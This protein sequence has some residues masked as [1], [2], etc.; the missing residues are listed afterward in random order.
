MKIRNEEKIRK[1]LEV[2]EVRKYKEGCKRKDD[3]I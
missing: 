1:K 2:R 3:E